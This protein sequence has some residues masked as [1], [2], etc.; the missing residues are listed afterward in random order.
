MT[1]KQYSK[2]QVMQLGDA[3]KVTLRLL[4]RGLREFISRRRLVI[5]L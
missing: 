5:T 2:P 3:I 4:P 1:N